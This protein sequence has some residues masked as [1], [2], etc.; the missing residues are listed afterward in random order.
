MRFIKLIFSSLLLI[1]SF[2]A[3]SSDSLSELYQTRWSGDLTCKR[4]PYKIDIFFIKENSGTASG[5]NKNYPADSFEI[6]FSYAKE[7]NVISFTSNGTDF[8]SGTWFI[9]KLNKKEFI[10][11]NKKGSVYEKVSLKRDE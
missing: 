4:G 7:G 5:V 2:S 9:T 8:L 6:T 3:C 1:L 11:D 10:F